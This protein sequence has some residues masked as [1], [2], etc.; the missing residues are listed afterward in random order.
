MEKYL[1]KSNFLFTFAA[2]KYSLNERKSY[3]CQKEH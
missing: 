3:L 1:E 2:D